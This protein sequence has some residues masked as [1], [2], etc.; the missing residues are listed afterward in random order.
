MSK[1]EK[2]LSWSL[3]GILYLV[4]LTPLLM[5]SDYVFP[6]ITPKT[7]YFRLMIELAVLI[8][9]AL[10]M[11]F[12]KYR[13]KMTKLSWLVIIFG[14]IIL[15]TG[16]FGVNFYK[17]F[18]G[19]IERGEGFLTISHLIIYFLL[20]TWTF[21]SKKAWLNF[22]AGI[23]IVGLFVNLYAFFQKI[24]V[25]HFFLFGKIINSG[26]DRLSATIGNAAFLGAYSLSLFWLNFLQ[27]LKRKNIYAKILFAL[28]GL[29][30]FYIL[31]NTQTRGALLAWIV[32]IIL[33][34]IFYL[35]K[36]SNKT[37]KMISGSF[38]AVIILFS[39]IVYAN[40]NSDWVKQN[41]T[42]FRLTS[43]SMNDITTEARL[44]AWDSSWKGWKDRFFIGYGWENYNIA[45]NK[46]FHPE[47]YIDQ[48]SQLW[49]DRAHNTIFDVAVATG[50]FGLINYLL[51]FGLAIYILF[52]KLKTDFDL[53]II[54][55]AFLIAHFLQNIFVFDVLASYVTLFTIFALISWLSLKPEDNQENKSGD[56]NIIYLFIAVIVMAFLSYTFNFK[57]LKANHL[58]IIAMAYA[59]QDDEITAIE[60]F[61]QALN[62][63]TYQSPELRQKLSDN[64]MLYNKPSQGLTN[65][66]IIDNYEFAI[67]EMKKNIEL[68]PRDVQNY[69]YLM[70]LLNRA[71]TSYNINYLNEVIEFGEKATKLSPTRPQIYFEMGQAM[72]A[73]NKMDQSI[74]YF[75]KGLELNPNNLESHWNL[76]AAYIVAGKQDLADAE[77][78]FMQSRG[79]D[80]EHIS[81][82]N[83]LYNVYL[84][85]NNKTKMVEI[86][87]KIVLVEPLADNYA[88]LAAAYAQVGNY[89]KA[90]QAVNKAVELEPSLATEAERFLQTLQ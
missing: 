43:I 18:W 51:I 88:R 40:K 60:K 37:K 31:F 86:L 39:V 65:Q 44:Y 4:L 27:F 73:Q 5:K 50:I 58:G 25:D 19:T 8:Y 11:S 77:Q 24:G 14:I 49:F 12:P 47:I 79:Y 87:E 90:I 56:F 71:G 26:G 61:E 64:I 1:T 29:F 42:L 78:E 30:S 13:P 63:N 32:V 46:Y 28:N 16:I 35:F 76:L 54:L 7:F 38:L 82:L 9:L 41:N 85:I 6:F 84:M 81:L 2:F 68:A 70:A 36:G 23:A 34:S 52:K 75:K 15:I 80:F 89:A 22:L 17:T 72:A 48:G 59:S 62:F 33:L 53:S 55:I 45:F 57:P 67:T 3:K 74:E 20:L 21:K 69:L 83:R 10:A 66:Q